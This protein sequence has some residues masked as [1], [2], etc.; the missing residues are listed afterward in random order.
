MKDR[1]HMD[2]TF[3]KLY[4]YDH[5]RQLL[6]VDDTFC[7]L[8]D[9]GPMHKNPILAHKGVDNKIIFRALNPD[10]TPSTI[11]CGQQV[12]ARIINPNNNT[13]VLEKLCTLGPAKGIINLMLDSGDIVDVA[14]GAYNMVIIR[15]EEFVSNIPGYYVEK[16]MYSD[17]ND[18]I[19]MEIVIT[20]QALK[21]PM[22]SITITEKDWTSD[23]TATTMTFGRPCFYS[24]RIPG[25]RV[26]NHK[27]SV[28]SFSTYTEN[29][30][31]TLEL[32]GTLE[33]TPDAYLNVGRWFKIY[34]STMSEDIEYVG[35][36]GT[37]AWTFQANCMW[38]KFRLLPSTA[39][40][41]H[42]RM[43]KIIIRN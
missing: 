19:S 31:G 10:R 16:P 40:F 38:M 5:V 18:N 24:S 23:W 25:G 28:Q 26:M 13:I 15:T 27:E 20:E 14:P 17:M 4:L 42:G 34:P 1:G 35:Y 11:P 2:V 32:W 22:P 43:A 37:Q 12:Y 21:A 9:N 7:P 36:T 8:K 3:H 29:F 33:E 39:V 6:A 41:D 30:T